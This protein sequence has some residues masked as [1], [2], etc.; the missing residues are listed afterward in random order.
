ME[1]TEEKANEAAK[2]RA[3]TDAVLKTVLNCTKKS[4]EDQGLI[5]ENND[6]TSIDAQNF[7]ILENAVRLDERYNF[8][9][10]PEQN[11]SS[12]MNNE[13]V[14]GFKTLRTMLQ[15]SETIFWNPNSS[16]QCFWRSSR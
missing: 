5:P 12:E 14:S 11:Y 1:A 15:K 9:N 10:S 8:K 16:L 4:S 6:N 2:T 3:F 13:T 7:Q